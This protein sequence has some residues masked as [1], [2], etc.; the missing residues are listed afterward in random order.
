MKKYLNI[1]LI[2]LFISIAV[3]VYARLAHLPDYV[4]RIAG[5]VSLVTMVMVAVLTVKFRQK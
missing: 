2:I 5:I 4:N 3:Q 1:S